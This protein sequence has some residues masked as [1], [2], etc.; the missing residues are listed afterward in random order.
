MIE[1]KPCNLTAEQLSLLA[2]PA[3]RG[4]ET[5]PLRIPPGTL[6]PVELLDPTGGITSASESPQAG[7]NDSADS[8]GAVTTDSKIPTQNPPRA[9]A[10]GRDRS[11]RGT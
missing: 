3:N 9:K 2:T 6:I 11:Q 10:R 8:I 7:P 4:T 5:V 1:T